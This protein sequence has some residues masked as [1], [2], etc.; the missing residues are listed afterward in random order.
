[1][2]DWLK[3][4]RA[5]IKHV[6]TIEGTDFMGGWKP[7][8]APLLGLTEDEMSSLIAEADAIMGEM[9]EAEAE[10]DAIMGEIP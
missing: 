10:A 6:A 4:L 5:Y 9:A 7:G 3:I 2:T 8:D 1:M